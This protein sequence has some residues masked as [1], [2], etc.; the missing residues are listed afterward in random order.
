M[1]FICALWWNSRWKL[2]AHL[3]NNNDKNKPRFCKTSKSA[4][5]KKIVV[6]PTLQDALTKSFYENKYEYIVHQ[7]GCS[8]VSALQ[9]TGRDNCTY[10]SRCCVFFVRTKTNP[11]RHHRWIHL[12]RCRSNGLIMSGGGLRSSRKISQKVAKTFGPPPPLHKKM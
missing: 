7:W 9:R 6:K 10:P 12:D 4:E 5:K 1:C 8:K 3:S 11:E 2:G